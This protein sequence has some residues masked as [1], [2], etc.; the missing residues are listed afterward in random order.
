MFKIR[1]SFFLRQIKNSFFCFSHCLVAIFTV[2]SRLND[3]LCFR[4][5]MSSHRAIFDNIEIML[6]V[7]RRRNNIGE[8]CDVINSANRF[9]LFLNFQLVCECDEVNRNALVVNLHHRVIDVAMCFRIEIFH[10]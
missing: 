8:I 7:C 5:Q 9:Q 3:F 2:K 6:K 4:N 10:I 1:R